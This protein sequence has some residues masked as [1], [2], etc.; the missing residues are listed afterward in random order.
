MKHLKVLLLIPSLL[1]SLIVR[2]QTSEED[3]Q[4]LLQ[5]LNA[6]ESIENMVINLSDINFETGTA[7]L[8]ERAMAYL[9]QVVSLM[10]KAPNIDL[11][12]KGHA[13]LTGSDALNNQLSLDRAKSVQDFLLSQSIE[14]ARLSLKGFG[15]SMPIA[16]NNTAEGRA[17]NRRVEMEV[18]KRKEAETIQDIIVLRNHQR[19]GSVI[20]AYD[21]E[22]I[23]YKQ[24]TD[25][26]TLSLSSEQVD[27]IYFSDGRVKAY[28]HSP[29]EKFKLGEWWKENV[30]IFKTSEAFHRGNFVLGLG[31]GIQNNVGIKSQ[32]NQINIPPMLLITEMPLG[33]NLGVGITAGSMRWSKKETPDIIYMY[34]AVSTRLAYHFNLGK[35]LDVYTGIAVTGRMGTVSNGEQNISRRELDVGLLLGTRYYLNSTFGVFA[36]IGDESV[37]YPKA[38]LAIRFGN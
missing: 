17:Q 32:T 19:I 18:L 7:H 11:Y 3:V 34:Y 10:K 15:S 8:E 20:I 23:T 13:D 16:D 24:F 29:K 1:L 31:I 33:Y 30:P 27:S 14:S 9:Q 22:N 36:E 4:L 2:G 5:K 28:Q 21:E 38:G 26:D 37:A 35:K 12:I 6:G 25:D